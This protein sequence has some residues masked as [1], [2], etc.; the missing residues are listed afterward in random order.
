MV[1]ITSSVE[2]P[3]AP[4]VIVHLNVADAP[5]VNPVTP[6]VA[7]VG[8]VIVAVPDIT[9]QAPVPAAGVLPARFV[10]VTLHKF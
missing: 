6:E 9:L 4:L 2:E 3:H 5:I 10:V 1:I 7:E 8:V